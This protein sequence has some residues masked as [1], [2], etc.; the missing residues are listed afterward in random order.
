MEKNQS[1]Q[2][3]LPHIS[4]SMPNEQYHRG[5]WQK[6]FVSSTTLKNFLVSPKFFKYSLLNPKQINPQSALQGSIYHSMMESLCN[7]DCIDG[8]WE[9]FF[10]FDAPVN[11]KTGLVYGMTTKAYQEAYI[12]A[13]EANGGKT[14]CSQEDITLAKTMVDCLLNNC[15]Q[16]SEVVKYLLEIGSAEV[17]FFAEYQGAKFKFRTDLKTSNKIVDWKTIAC[18]D[19]HEDTINKQIIKM[20]Y[21]FSAAFYQFFCH[22]ITGKWNEFYWVFQQKSAPYDAVIVNSAPYAYSQDFNGDI[23][24]GISAIE[25]EKVLAQYIKCSQEQYYPGAEYL[26]EPTL[27]YRIMYPK[28]PT[29]KANSI[30]NFFNND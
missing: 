5:E 25:F 20:N 11:P 24:K 28:V 16:T 2:I 12:E 4:M 26:I 6:E 29:Y 14:P 23:I 18:D 7:N 9:E 21:G 27:G 15:G 19:L 17:S 3:T 13:Q 10:L 30:I 22:Q 8:V 1:I